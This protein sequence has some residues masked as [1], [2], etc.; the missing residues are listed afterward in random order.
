M[1]WPFARVG[2]HWQS[3]RELLPT[4][5][6]WRLVIEPLAH[7]CSEVGVIR[8]IGENLGPISNRRQRAELLLLWLE[9]LLQGHCQV[10]ASAEASGQFDTAKD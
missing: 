10:T 2:R 5:W 7:Y 3:Q 9:P 8:I 6:V 1:Q 4:A